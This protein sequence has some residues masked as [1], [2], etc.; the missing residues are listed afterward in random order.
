MKVFSM[1][2][3]KCPSECLFCPLHTGGIKLSHDECGKKVTQNIAGGWKETKRVPDERCL[4]HEIG[5]D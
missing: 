3:D 5:G 4:I 2:V 1:I